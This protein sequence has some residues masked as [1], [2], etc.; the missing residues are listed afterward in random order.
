M[1]K[2]TRVISVCA[3]ALLAVAPVVTPAATAHAETTHATVPSDANSN[4]I[5]VT[6]GDVDDITNHDV[7]VDV[8][9]TN[10]ASLTN[11]SSAADATADIS[12][13]QGTAKLLKDSKV[14]IVKATDKITD[15]DY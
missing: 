7:S 12:S 11:G 9:V 14:Y 2:R 1:K 15:A 13:S 8:N 4:E 6:P 5:H 3:A 10:A